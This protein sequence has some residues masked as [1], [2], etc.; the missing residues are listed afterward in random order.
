VEQELDIELANGLLR[1]HEALSQV[2]EP[3]AIVTTLARVYA[4]YG[5]MA[6]YLVYISNDAK[7]AP[8]TAEV[9]ESWGP[10]LSPP[11]SALVGQRFN[12]AD[13]ELGRILIERPDAPL[14]LP[15]IEADPETAAGFHEFPG[16]VGAA[17]ALPLYSRRH[18]AWQGIAIVHWAGPHHPGPAERLLHA[19]TLTTLA[20]SIASERTLHAYRQALAASQ[21]QRAMLQLILDTLPIG[22]L[23]M[24]GLDGE[25]ELSNRA[26]RR[27]LGFDPNASAFDPRAVQYHLPGDEVPIGPGHSPAAQALRTGATCRDEVEARLPN[28]ERKLLD[29]TAS[30]LHY[31]DDP[32]TR[33]VALYQD[34][35]EV[36]RAER[37]RLQAQEQ[38]LQVQSLALAER[39]TPLIPIREDV[40]ILPLVGSIDE[41]R[42]RQILETLVNLGGRTRVRATIID[43]TGV[44]NLDIAGARVLISAA[45]A[46]RLRGVRPILTGIQSSAAMTLVELGVDFTGIVVRGTMQ[47]GVTLATRGEASV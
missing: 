11:A 28:G 23:V 14:I 18:A 3:A 31:A 10:G 36:R 45:Q 29:L 35:T 21:R 20:E 1:A 38:L 22:V 2:A 9:V 32:E 15:D 41:E 17:L 26:G 24:R 25:V 16:S 42:G 12:I 7:G 5:P 33:L 19:L 43:V 47:D 6:I 8:A 4:P 34:V 46:L 40:L 13:F 30:P 27:V 44:R 39:S 37:E